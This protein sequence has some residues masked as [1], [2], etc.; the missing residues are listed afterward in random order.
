MLFPSRFVDLANDPID[1]RW[2]PRLH[3]DSPASPTML[4]WNLIPRV[5]NGKSTEHAACDHRRLHGAEGVGSL[6]PPD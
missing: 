3:I 6:R 1:F 2:F 4:Y 5:A